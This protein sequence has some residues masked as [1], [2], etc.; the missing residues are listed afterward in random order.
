MI[1]GNWQV[2]QDK[3]GYYAVFVKNGLLMWHQ[4]NSQSKQEMIELAD[5]L[6]QENKT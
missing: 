2:R 3:N 5:R 1:Q 4:G 6:N